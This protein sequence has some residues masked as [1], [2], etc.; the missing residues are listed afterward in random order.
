MPSVMKEEKPEAYRK[1][2]GP[3]ITVFTPTYN[4]ADCLRDAYAALRRQ[5]CK[6]FRWLVVDDGSTDCTREL[7][8]SWQRECADFEIQYIYQPNQGLYAG[9]TTAI[10]HIETELCVAVDSDDY[11][12]DDAIEKILRLWKKK[13]SNQVAGIV[14]PDQTRD[15]RMIGDPLPD[16]ETVNLIDLYIGK[17]DLR[18]GDRKNVLRTALYR[19][20]IPFD[21]VPGEKDF[22]PH[23]LHLVISREY[24]FLV[25]NEPLCVVS[26]QQDGMTA[27]VFRQYL[28]SPKSFRIMRQLDLSLANARPLYYAKKTIHYISSSLLSCQPVLSGTPY[29][30][31]AAMLFP[32]GALFTIILKWM[33]RWNLGPFRDAKHRKER[34]K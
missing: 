13:G 11:L 27:T 1:V 16:Q 9:Y 18:N 19:K 2:S 5:T 28:R 29:P 14:T 30:L 24:D 6:E 21:A 7:V 23:Y 3:G 17:Y 22:N 26:Y 25:L 33:N 31:L 12:T 15:G 32:A 20:A 10:H 34:K 8:L 4:R